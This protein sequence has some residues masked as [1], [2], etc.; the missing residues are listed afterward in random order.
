MVR[1][2]DEPQG[3][4]AGKA[5]CQVCISQLYCDGALYMTMALVVSAEVK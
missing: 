5:A 4:C 1:Q 3:V 2:V